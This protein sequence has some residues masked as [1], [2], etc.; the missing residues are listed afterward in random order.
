MSDF[1][2]R[3]MCIQFRAG[4]ACFAVF[5]TSADSDV[6]NAYCVMTDAK[7]SVTRR[8]LPAIS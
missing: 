6:A 1:G 3:M 4:M 8:A 7:K 2:R 5:L